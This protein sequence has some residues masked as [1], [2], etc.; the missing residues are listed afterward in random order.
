MIAP[1]V[2]T[3]GFP[4]YP[5]EAGTG[6]LKIAPAGTWTWT[7]KLGDGAAYSM[8]GRLAASGRFAARAL[9]YDKR[10]TIQGWQV[11]SEAAPKVQGTLEWIKNPTPGSASY[12]AGIPL[13]SVTVLPE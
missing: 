2:A 5:R 4:E 1:T 7:G 13:H 8:A 10:G 12:A 9:L 11:L 3:I 6:T